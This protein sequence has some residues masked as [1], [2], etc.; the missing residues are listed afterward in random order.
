VP[1]VCSSVNRGLAPRADTDRMYSRD[2]LAADFRALG[3]SPGEVVMVHASVRAVGEVA[4]GP[5]QIH[6]ALS[7]AL[8]ED[9]TLMMYA[10]CPRYFDEIGR[11]DLAAEEEAEL[12]EKLP[13]FDPLTARSARD[14]G[15]LVEFLRTWPGTRVNPH[16][17]RFAARGARVDELFSVQPWNYAFGRDSPLDRFAALDG[18]ILMLG[19]DLDTVTFLHYVEHIADTPGRRVAKFRVPVLENGTRVW[20]DCEEFDTSDVGAHPAWPDQFFA[21]LV[22]GFLDASGNTGG[23]VG[24]APCYLM[25]ARDLMAYAKPIMEATAAGG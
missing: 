22:R 17:A 6:L 25:S 4:G 15:I 11:G 13:A 24:D 19:A 14:H 3:I 21:T 10:G 12:L 8:G 7:D 23:R 18:R 2:E 16:V 9:G 20:R 5:D 1:P